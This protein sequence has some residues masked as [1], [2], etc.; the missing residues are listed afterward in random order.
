MQRIVPINYD[1]NNVDDVNNVINK[2]SKNKPLLVWD[3]F[4]TSIW[5]ILQKKRTNICFSESSH[6]NKRSMRLL[7][8]FPHHTIDESYCIFVYKSD[9]GNI[10]ILFTRK[11]DHGDYRALYSNCK[12][13]GITKRLVA[14]YNSNRVVE[15]ST[16]MV[17]NDWQDKTLFTC[18]GLDR[19]HDLQILIDYINEFV[20]EGTNNDTIATPL[21][22]VGRESERSI[23]SNKSELAEVTINNITDVC[24]IEDLI[25]YQRRIESAPQRGAPFNSVTGNTVEDSSAVR[26]EYFNGV[27]SE[28]IPIAQEII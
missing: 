22:K 16:F 26:T 10:N 3:S 20:Q 1:V 21:L 5:R 23:Q 19:F 25:L 8:E 2:Y 15:E 9:T 24:Y 17:S 27:N 6:D 28:E 13:F 14:I 11:T 4:P 18:I 12:Y 7:I